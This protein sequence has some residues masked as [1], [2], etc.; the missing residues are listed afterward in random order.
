[1]IKKKRKEKRK[2]DKK[3]TRKK[4]RKNKTHLEKHFT[5]ELANDTDAIT[6]FFYNTIT[7]VNVRVIA[8]ALTM[9]TKGNFPPGWKSHSLALNGVVRAEAEGSVTILFC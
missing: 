2:G 1:M 7:D 3:K 4:E 8:V 5:K 9:R 6:F